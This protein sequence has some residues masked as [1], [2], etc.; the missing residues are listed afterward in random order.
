MALLALMASC[1]TTVLFEPSL[2][3]F[4]RSVVNKSPIV[5]YMYHRKALLYQQLLLNCRTKKRQKNNI[6]QTTDRTWLFLPQWQAVLLLYYLS[7]YH[8]PHQL[9]VVNKSPIIESI[10]CNQSLLNLSPGSCCFYSTA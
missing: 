8:S 7:L 10:C 3:S 2:S 6:S 9:P 5:E 1:T 4:A